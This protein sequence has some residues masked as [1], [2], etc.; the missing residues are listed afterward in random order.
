MRVFR[1]FVSG[2]VA[3]ALLLPVAL[4][5]QELRVGL[6]LEPTSI[7]PHYHNLT[8]NNALAREIFDRLVMPDENQQLKPGLAVS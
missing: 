7:A 2:V 1:H 6:A 8:P 5:A 3:T 4:S